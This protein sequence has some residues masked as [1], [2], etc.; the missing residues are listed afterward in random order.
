MDESETRT[1]DLVIPDEATGP[2][3]AAVRG[4]VLLY[5]ALAAVA[6]AAIGLGSWAVLQAPLWPAY[7][8]PAATA[9]G[10]VLHVR[11]RL[12]TDAADYAPY[13]LDSAVAT[14]LADDSAGKRAGDSSAIP[15]WKRPYVSMETSAG[16]VDVIVVWKRSS[17]QTSW[18]EANRF[19]MVLDGGTWKMSDAE[20][21]DELSVPEPMRRR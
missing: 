5:A 13:V 17:V 16:A 19:K 2:G 15:G 12:S 3:A 7:S 6:V 8:H 21:L 18:P 20:T 11:S 4:R 14:A 9:V 10:K 1:D